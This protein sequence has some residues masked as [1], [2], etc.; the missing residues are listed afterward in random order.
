MFQAYYEYKH[1]ASLRTVLLNLWNSIKSSEV[2]PKSKFGRLLE[3]THYSAVKCGCRDYPVLSGIVL[4]VATTLLRYTDLLLADRAYY[5]AGIEA[6]T[7]GK[8]A[9]AFVFLN[10]F[11]DLEE[12]IEE[13]D[14]T[15]LDVDDLAVTDFPVEVPLP[16]KL[17]LTAE[18]REEAREW[19]LAVSMDQKVEQVLPTDHRGVYIGSLTARTT[20]SGNLQHCIL[21][22]YPVQGPIIRFP[23][24]L[25]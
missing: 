11:L 20:D 10:H 1:L 15:V 17:S 2:E 8:N 14:S 19:V 24:V 23:E 16:Q 21:T 4:K 3:A 7:A 18:Q 22:G 25:F 12:C 13:G 9:E 6:R 5:E